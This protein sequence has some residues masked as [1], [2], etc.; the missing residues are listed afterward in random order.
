MRKMAVYEMG[1][2]NLII[3]L[4]NALLMCT[5]TKCHLYETLI[6]ANK[7]KM[8]LKK[9]L[10]PWVVFFD[11][12]LNHAI[13]GLQV[14]KK[15]KNI[16]KSISDKLVVFFDVGLAH[17]ITRL[18]K[19]QKSEKLFKNQFQTNYYWLCA[20]NYTDEIL[21]GRQCGLRIGGHFCMSCMC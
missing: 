21:M 7:C 11:V 8:Y 16:E 5:C 19:W 17:A 1:T 2:Y 6:H 18:T 14:E 10:L 3:K 9:S 13:K 20:T 4:Q 15:W 12:G